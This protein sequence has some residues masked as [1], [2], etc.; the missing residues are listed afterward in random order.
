MNT[1]SLPIPDSISDHTV[2]SRDAWIQARKALLEKE[3]EHLS[4]HDALCEER[5]A[6]PWVR[7]EKPYFFDT[8]KG[9][10]TLAGL[11]EGRSQLVLYHFMMGP[12][13]KEGC[14]GC[15]FA[16]D[17]IEGPL[18]HL[19]HHDVSVVVVSRAP[20]NEIEAFKK[21]MGWR[22]RWV[23]S[24]GTDFNYD[25]HVSFTKE[26]ITQ[27]KVY[28]GFELIEGEEEELPGVSVFFKD[29]ADEVY[30]TYSAYGRGPEAFLGAYGFLDLTPRGRDEKSPCDWV[31][32]HD[33]YEFPRSQPAC[34]EGAAQQ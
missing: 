8:P 13:W 16:V 2:V 14:V 25:Y 34:C 23:S 12:G 29:G 7:V 10:T 18:V 15:S 3:K 17:H 4:R 22:F 24:H 20:L 21:R 27:G 33:R 5:R 6:L 32:H 9:S 31:R 11:F 28:Y 26:Q 1:L 30:H 19:E